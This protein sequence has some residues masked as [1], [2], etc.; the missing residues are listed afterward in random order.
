M[1]ASG[2]KFLKSY[3]KLLVGTLIIFFLPVLEDVPEILILLL[4]ILLIVPFK[5][6]SVRS[7]TIRLCLALSAVLNSS[8]VSI[9][10]SLLS[11]G[12]LFSPF[13]SA[14]FKAIDFNCIPESFR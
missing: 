12:S 2:G 7:P 1:I 14:F 8:T 10:V 9:P 6:L 3:I 13:A 5:F 4:A 11:S